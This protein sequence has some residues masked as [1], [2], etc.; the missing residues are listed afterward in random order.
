MRRL[1]HNGA[2][3]MIVVTPTACCCP[4][5]P[6]LA[7]PIVSQSHAELASL[8]TPDA[9]RD[10]VADS[11][12]QAEFR[13]VDF[14][15][16]PGVILGIRQLRGE[17]VSKTRGAPVVFDDK[18]SFVIRLAS[19][20][21]AI[22]TASLAHLMNEHVF[23]YR[24]APLRNLT[25]STRGDE[26]IQRGVLRKVVDI[27]FEIRAKLSLTPDGRIRVHP[28]E[29][30]ICSINGQGLM[31]ALGID[32]A[33]LLDVSK[34]KGVQV[35]KNDML[36]DADRLLPPPAIQGR[37]TSVRIEQ[38][39]LVQVF[40]DSAAASRLPRLPP[41]AGG[42]NYMYFNGGTLRFGKL[43]MVRA[44]MRILDADPSDAFAFSIDLYNDQLV[45]GYSK[46]RP[47][48]GLD[49]FMPD[50][51]ELQRTAVSAAKR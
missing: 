23:G 18:H 5:T 41:A 6:A 29:M 10:S 14:Q 2:A 20:E 44:D 27:P 32:L 47:D 4:R 3:L 9:V 33:D 11:V 17:F 51:D 43:F 25:F 36:L 1:L 7:A 15:I 48:L 16:A 35:E 50:L 42:A 26:L 46:N 38:G 40:G 21:I 22:D 31:R 30:K 45:A 19:A 37:L 8:P 28:T 49:V 24:G 13:N 39:R 12:T 34:A